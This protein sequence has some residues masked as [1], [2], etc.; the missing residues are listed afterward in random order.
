MHSQTLTH[1]LVV[2]VGDVAGPAAGP[3]S[4]RVFVGDCLMIIMCVAAQHSSHVSY[5]S[6]A[7]C[8]VVTTQLFAVLP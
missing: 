6:T 4:V 2:R 8:G 3:V 7:A 1:Q 5:S